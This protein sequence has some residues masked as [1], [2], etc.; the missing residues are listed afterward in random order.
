MLQPH[1]HPPVTQVQ[2]F[3]WWA[4][5]ASIAQ[6]YPRAWHTAG[7]HHSCW[8][9]YVLVILYVKVF[10][11]KE[12]HFSLSCE[13]ILF[14]CCFWNSVQLFNI[15][16]LEITLQWYSLS[17]LFAAFAG[18][19]KGCAFISAIDLCSRQND[20]STCCGKGNLLLTKYSSEQRLIVSLSTRGREIFSDL[21]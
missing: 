14:F 13:F 11:W 3:F 12:H 20:C 9:L 8:V 10:S 5:C 17:R 15:F 16:F 7:S 18:V 1:W 19:E 2:D 6:Y 4:V 21:V